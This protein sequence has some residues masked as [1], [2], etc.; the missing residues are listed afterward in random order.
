MTS[1]AL[2][3]G[4][5]LVAIGTL[6]WNVLKGRQD[7]EDKEEDRGQAGLVA[8]NTQLL[9]EKRI[10]LEQAARKDELLRSKDTAIQELKGEFSEFK[11]RAE[12]D[13]LATQER[14]ENCL[15]NEGQQLQINQQMQDKLTMVLSELEALR[16]ESR[17]SGDS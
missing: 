2:S 12:K 7:R 15:R 1:F 11:R 5:L 17:R 8:L 16:I 10:L 4:A 14:L 6:V 9:D 13:H 3:V